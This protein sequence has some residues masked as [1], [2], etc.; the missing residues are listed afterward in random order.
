M[1]AISIDKTLSWRIVSG[2]RPTHA[3]VIRIARTRQAHHIQIEGCDLPVTDHSNRQHAVME[4]VKQDALI[5]VNVEGSD[6]ASLRYLTGF[7]G[8]GAVILS[9]DGALL[10]TDSRYTEQAKRETSGIEI[11][12]QRSWTKDAAIEAITARGFKLVAFPSTRVSYSWVK[13]IED[14]AT[15]ALIPIA[16]PVAQVRRVKSP[17][18]VAALKRA[19]KIA[20]R[21]LE[22]LVDEIRIGMTEAEV[23]LQLEWFIRNDDAEGLGFDIDVSAGENTAL[24]HYNPFLDPRPLQAGDLLLF[25]FGAMVDGYRS[26][27]TRTFCVKPAPQQAVD[28]YDLVLR[29]NLAAIN[30]VRSGVTGIEVDAVARDLIN[31]EGHGEHFGHGLGHGIGLE[32]HEGPSLSPMSKDTLETGMVATIE[33]GVYL[34]GFGGVRIEDDVVV[35]EDGC[36]I[37][38]FF[39]KDRLIEVG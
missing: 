4:R 26:D 31:A 22:Q 30:A 13:S 14:K 10:L 34:P 2:H 20:D 24:N 21:A 36:E 7:T 39:P 16:D 3:A 35:T 5:L 6:R 11:I 18:E 37:I 32:V 15:F 28:I 25:D 33:P 17:A 19:A 38:T 12:E 29:A 27:M 8:E 9:E 1:V 23:A